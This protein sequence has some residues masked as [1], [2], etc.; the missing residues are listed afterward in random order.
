M[1]VSTLPRSGRISSCGMARGDLRLAPQAGGADHRAGRQGGEIFMARRDERIARVLAR[2]DRGE[3]EARRQLGRHVLHRVHRDVGAA[4]GQR[5]LQLLDEQALAAL[6]GERHV[7][8]FVAARRQ[9]HQRRRAGPGCSASR[10]ALTCSACHSASRLRRV[11]MRSSR[12]RHHGFASGSTLFTAGHW[13]RLTGRRS[14]IP[15][16]TTFQ[17][18]SSSPPPATALEAADRARAPPGSCGA[19]ARNARRIRARCRTSGSSIRCSPARV[20]SVTYFSSALRIQHLARPAPA[21]MRLPLGHREELARARFA[22]WRVSRR[23]R[24][25]GPAACAFFSAA[26]RRSARTGFIR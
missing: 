17:C 24:G 13:R 10:R 18:G 22:A 5:R 1:R 12:S 15:S 11:A 26:A 9:R 23:S 19:R 3:R 14:A 7:E 2:E 8:Q 6:L 4:L 21:T 20:R 25:A 16:S